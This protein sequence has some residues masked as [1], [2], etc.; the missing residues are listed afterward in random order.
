MMSSS[1]FRPFDDL[2]EHYEDEWLQLSLED[3]TLKCSSPPA[4]GATDFGLTVSTRSC[5]SPLS[6]I[7]TREPYPS[8]PPPKLSPVSAEQQTFIT[9][10]NS[11]IPSVSS[12]SSQP[13]LQPPPQAQSSEVTSVEYELNP[14]LSM[15]S[16]PS[17]S[18]LLVTKPAELQFTQPSVS[19]LHQNGDFASFVR[20]EQREKSLYLVIIS[21]ETGAHAFFLYKFESQDLDLTKIIFASALAI[22]Y[23]CALSQEAFFVKNFISKF[24]VQFDFLLNSHSGTVI[25]PQHHPSG[26]VQAVNGQWFVQA[27]VQH[28]QTSAGTVIAVVPNFCR[29]QTQPTGNSQN[30]SQAQVSQS[31]LIAHPIGN[32]QTVNTAQ[33][34]TVSAQHVIQNHPH[35]QIQQQQPQQIVT[36]VPR[37]LTV[38]VTSSAPQ[39][40]QSVMQHLLSQPAI[41]R[42]QVQAAVQ[43]VAS[44]PATTK[45][46][47][48]SQPRNGRRKNTNQGGTLGSV[49]IKANKLAAA[50]S[51]D[52]SINQLL[53]PSHGIEMRL[54][55]QNSEQ[56]ANLSKEISRLQNLQTAYNVDHSAEIKEL[57]NKRAQIFFEALAQQHK[58]KDLLS[59]VNPKPITMTAHT[60]QRNYKNNHNSGQTTVV[61]HQV[62][63]ST[64]CGQQHQQQPTHRQQQQQ[65]NYEAATPAR[66]PVSYQNSYQISTHYTPT[67]E[68]VQSNQFSVRN[69]NQIQQVSTTQYSSYRTAVSQPS[70]QQNQVRENYIHSVPNTVPQTVILQ[71]EQ[72]LSRRV[73]REVPCEPPPPPVPL[74][75]PPTLRSSA[76][77]AACI[78]T[79]KTERTRRINDY[80]LSLH[81]SVEHSDVSS[82]FH[83]LSDALQRLLPFH[84][85]SEPDFNFEILDTFDYHCLRHFVH[86]NNRR[87]IVEQRVRSLLCKEA[88]EGYNKVDECLLLSLDAEHERRLLDEEKRMA[89][90]CGREEFVANSSICSRMNGMDV[91]GR[92]KELVPIS[93]PKLHF[94]Y[95]TFSESEIAARTISPFTT[96][97]S[98]KS[99]VSN[100]TSSDDEERMVSDMTDE[101]L[102]FEETTEITDTEDVNDPDTKENVTKTNGEK[103]LVTSDWIDSNP[104]LDLPATVTCCTSWRKS[105]SVSS[106]QELYSPVTADLSEQMFVVKNTVPSI[107][108]TEQ[109]EAVIALTHAATLDRISSPTTAEENEGI[110]NCVP[111]EDSSKIN[112]MEVASCDNDISQILEHKGEAERPERPPIRIKIALTDASLK[113]C[114]NKSNSKKNKGKKKK[115]KKRK[116]CDP[117]ETCSKEANGLLPSYSGLEDTK[118]ED[119][120]CHRDDTSHPRILMRIT[121][122]NNIV[123]VTDPRTNHISLHITPKSEIDEEREPPLKVPKLKIRLGRN[124]EEHVV[125]SEQ[126]IVNHVSKSAPHEMNRLKMRFGSNDV[127]RLNRRKRTAGVDHNRKMTIIIPKSVIKN[128]YTSCNPGNSISATVSSNAQF[129]PN[130]ELSDEEEGEQLR[131]QADSVISRL[132]DWGTKNPVVCQADAISRLVGTAPLVTPV[133]DRLLPSD[134]WFF[135]MD[136]KNRSAIDSSDTTPS[137]M[138]WLASAASHPRSLKT[139]ISISKPN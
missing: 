55:V 51:T 73:V 6:H 59:V 38:G 17:S 18:P 103:N 31:Q 117:M 111:M 76:E 105:D 104:S 35:H 66:V 91:E 54:S 9:L 119:T 134:P 42:S 52:A 101:M 16:I 125:D 68:T 85:Y 113:N 83:D 43:A 133:L 131:A 90:V 87:H 112:E 116:H 32:G 88:M 50:A 65:P 23:D 93:I 120:A 127:D 1:G 86:L 121:R 10:S 95:H 108:S 2:S 126:P 82:P 49:L 138:T 7:P 135:S 97:D 3:E 118:S 5:P 14:D 72:H 25:Q 132:N 30:L 123:S 75:P 84:V 136:V 28:V 109:L 12:G 37:S 137:H 21:I 47:R 110:E 46:Q 79:K 124:G 94:D 19:G 53:P 115:K 44:V 106:Y 40:G 24:F 129:S 33:P 11:R 63:P 139:T 13:I 67:H 98:E 8:E 78:A 26:C 57:E 39:Q 64:S 100:S 15:L 48:N 77:T 34:T 4:S 102:V 22:W 80:F 92:R 58:D 60:S 27:Q 114:L 61:V 99:P 128:S 41:S 36:R 74:F 130:S 122:K 71:P 56:V 20:L 96:S 45:K 81:N 89:V 70:L 107:K 29:P 62:Q 69:N